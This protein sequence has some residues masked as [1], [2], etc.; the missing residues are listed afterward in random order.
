MLRF[1]KVGVWF[2]WNCS[3]SLRGATLA[4]AERILGSGSTPAQRRRLARAVIGNFY[5]FLL[6]IGR[7]RGRSAAELMTEIESIE[8]EAGYEQARAAGKGAILVTAHIGSFEVGAVVLKA[9]EP[10]VRVVFQRDPM[11]VFENLRAEQHRRVGLIEAPVNPASGEDAWTVWLSLR[12]ALLANEVVL[13]QGDRVMPGQRGL[14][15][16]FLGGHIVM[17]P[18]PV[19][20]ALATGAPL[21]PVCSP[22]TPDGRV[23]IIMGKPIWVS[24]SGDSVSGPH[25]AVFEL[26]RVIEG[27]VST[28]PEQWMM[29]QRVWCEDGATGAQP[30]E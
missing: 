23:R 30:T 29:V 16:P 19:K 6:D 28:F 26:A 18:G 1:R 17:P 22:R 15:M 14:R 5:Q 25:P 3:A 20:L 13:M 9:K 2:A 11:P 10:S 21:I 7:H 8:G 27:W 24:A 12:D 4:N